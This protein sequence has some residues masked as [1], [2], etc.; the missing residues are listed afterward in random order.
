MTWFALIDCNNFYASV[1]RVFEPWV[2]NSPII[3]LSNNDGCTIARSYEAKNLGIKMGEVYHLNIERYKQ[4]GV[5]IRSSCYALFGNM[6]DRVMGILSKYTD[7]IE[8]YSVD[9]SFL[10]LKGFDEYFDV[11]SYMQQAVAEVLQCTGIPISV[12]LAPTKALAKVSNKVAKKFPELTGHVHWINTEELRVKGLKWTK[13][14]DVWGIGRKHT[15]KLITLEER[16]V[17]TT[18]LMHVDTCRRKNI[19]RAYDFTLLDRAFVRQEFTVVGERLHK[20]L[21]GIQ[22]LD[23]EIEEPN[24]NM[25]CARSFE[26]FLH[27][28]EDISEQLSSYVAHVCRRLRKQR[29]LCN[30]ISVFIATS[31]FVNNKRHKD[32]RVKLP[33]STNS[34]FE[35]NYYAQ[36]MLRAI[37]ASGF[38]Y[39]KAGVTLSKL[40]PDDT[41]QVSL[42]QNRNERHPKLMKVFDKMNRKY[43]E[44]TLMAASQPQKTF[45]MRQNFMRP[46]WTCKIADVLEINMDLAHSIGNGTGIAKV[47]NY[48]VKDYPPMIQEMEDNLFSVEMDNVA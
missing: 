36:A 37:Y 7:A 28:R 38:S 47:I 44:N 11:K 25:N 10:K 24:D 33:Y 22:A 5:E 40:V 14:E 21:C 42:F 32:I 6:S 4:L 8:V 34:Q 41:I 19:E 39:V 12:G 46:E 15:W 17:Q 31:Q 13:I 45:N 2:M 1:F 3:V 35:I 23:L 48:A 20:E 18:P 30:Q 27:K 26:T 43:G 16:E 29:R 9:E